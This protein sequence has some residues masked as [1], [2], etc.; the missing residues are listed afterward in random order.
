VKDKFD[1][2]HGGSKLAANDSNLSPG[3]LTFGINGVKMTR[4]ESEL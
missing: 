4:S 1:N 2:M 3:L